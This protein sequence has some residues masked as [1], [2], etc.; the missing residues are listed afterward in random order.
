MIKKMESLEE[1]IFIICPVREL[2]QEEDFYLQNYIS[3]LENRG[4]KVHY[5]PRDTNQNDPTGLNICTENRLAIIKS[6]E[7]QIYYAS[8]SKGT[9]FD[10]GMTFMA[11]KPL[12]V[13][14]ADILKYGIQ[15]DFSKF[16]FK[17]AYNTRWMDKDVPFYKDLAK[18]REEIK[19]SELIEY[20]WK[21]NIFEDK[22][23]F[24]F[25]FGMA[26]MA[27]KP[28]ILK[29]KNEVK[30]TPYKSFQNV[31]LELDRKYRKWKH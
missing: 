24:L 23:G 13:I 22:I 11:E 9:P 27:E 19:K 31:L 17:Y 8:K 25:D 4:C 20:E 18:R 7:V 2:T 16:L 3:G 28:I 5:P 15:D 14:N 21:E 1:I 10:L 29:N 12:Y 6:D 26:F 30:R